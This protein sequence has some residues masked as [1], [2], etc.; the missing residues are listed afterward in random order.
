MTKIMIDGLRL[1]AQIRTTFMP[2]VTP[3]LAIQANRR[4]VKNDYQ[5]EALL[6]TASLLRAESLLIGSQFPDPGCD[7]SDPFVFSPIMPATVPA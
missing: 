5:V 2:S 7:G 3:K 4:E 6:Q 1:K